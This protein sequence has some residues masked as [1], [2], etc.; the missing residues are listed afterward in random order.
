LLLRGRKQNFPVLWRTKLRLT[1]YHFCFS[2]IFPWKSCLKTYPD[3]RR[4]NK[5]YFL[6]GRVEGDVAH[7]QIG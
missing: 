2:A 1:K 3:S 4:R 6:D 7:K 5:P